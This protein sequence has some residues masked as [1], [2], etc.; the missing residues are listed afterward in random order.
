[1]LNALP[2]PT[3]VR[4]HWQFVMQ[5]FASFDNCFIPN[6]KSH[7]VGLEQKQYFP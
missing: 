2:E 7:K 6:M 5:Y 4:T 1:M 3:Q